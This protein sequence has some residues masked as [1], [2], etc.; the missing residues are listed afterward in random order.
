V[1]G[2][3][4]DSFSVDSTS[5]RSKLYLRNDNV[6]SNATL[7]KP[8]RLPLRIEVMSTKTIR[9][10]TRDVDGS[11]K[12]RDLDGFDDLIKS[13]EQIGIDDSSTDLTLR[14]L[15]VFR[16]LIGPI[17]E[18]RVIARYESPEVFE[19][20]T[21]EWANLK[22]PR[23]RRRRRSEIDADEKAKALAMSAEHAQDDDSDAEPNWN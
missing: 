7:P 9:I 8:N 20:L 14:G 2:R 17:P 11:L 21:K 3:E 18:G 19:V 22:A 12:T 15:P 1:I 13:H 10:V 16:G 23:R 4:Q 5:S 6:A